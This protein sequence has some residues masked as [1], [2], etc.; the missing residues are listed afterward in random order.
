MDGG[1]VLINQSCHFI[2]LLQWIGGPID[3]IYAY[4]ATRVHKIETEDVGV[5]VLKFKSGAL[6]VVEATTAAYGNLSN[7]LE[8]HGEKGTYILE[9][10]DEKVSL[11]GF[12]KKEES[13]KPEE[14]F[15]TKEGDSNDIFGL[16]HRAQFQDVASA[17]NENRRPFINGLEGRKPLEIIMGIYESAT[18]GK[19]VKL[20]LAKR[21]TK[22][23]RID[24]EGRK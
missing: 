23:K 18:T 13:N 10:Y 11:R 9:E 5:A 12:L 4:T 19:A 24:K 8:I 1:A 21:K 7:S 14:T 15:G 3:S 17:I 6:G 16:A 2:D 22:T 20:P